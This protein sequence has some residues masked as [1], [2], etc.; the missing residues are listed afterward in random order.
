MD[1]DFG[2]DSQLDEAALLYLADKLTIED[3]PV[4]LE[5]RFA[6][7]LAKYAAD[8]PACTAVVKRLAAARNIAAAVSRISG[9]QAEN[10]V[11]MGA[12]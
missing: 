12:D 10:M 3:R 2:P 6:L 7:A 9:R 4:S 11:K 5:E 8:G 1:L